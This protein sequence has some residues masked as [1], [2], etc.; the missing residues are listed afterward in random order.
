MTV[1]TGFGGQKY[2]DSCT[3]KIKDVRAEIERRGLQVDVAV[4][5]GVNKE[6]VGMILDAGANV[7][8]SGSA[9]FKGD[10]EANVEYFMDILKMHDL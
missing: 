7:I 1:S 4:D 6:N 10:I 5:G 9:V 3:Q 2:L 8:V